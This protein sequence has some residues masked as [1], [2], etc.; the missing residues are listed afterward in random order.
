MDV[1]YLSI[2]E[3]ATYD[4]GWTDSTIWCWELC[5]IYILYIAI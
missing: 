5:T 4:F 1:L 3:V 2:Q